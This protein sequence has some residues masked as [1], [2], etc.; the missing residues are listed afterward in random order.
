MRP[1]R[2]NNLNIKKFSGGFLLAELLVGVT[3][4]AII[5]ISVYQTYTSIFNSVY[6]SRAKINAV[7][8]IDEE[9]EIVRN[10]PYADVGIVGSIPSGKLVRSQSLVRGGNQFD[11]TTTGRN[12]DDPFDGTLGGNPND[13]SPP[14]KFPAQT[15]ES[16][17]GG[18]RQQ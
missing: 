5:A 9:L 18:L 14:L 1:K 16:R 17:F 2:N 8:L 13:R 12:V 7:D 15:V 6:L 10:L 4:F 3:V 11:V